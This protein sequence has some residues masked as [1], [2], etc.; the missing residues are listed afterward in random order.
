MIRIR[1]IRY[2]AFSIA[3]FSNLL[4]K[5]DENDWLGRAV[6]FACWEAIRKWEG[7]GLDSHSS[8]HTKLFDILVAVSRNLLH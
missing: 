8:F 5:Q 6:Y 1:F 4:E 7:V 3:F 2:T